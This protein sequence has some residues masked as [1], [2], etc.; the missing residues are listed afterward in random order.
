MRA[1]KEHATLKAEV[2]ERETLKA[3]YIEDLKAAEA[4]LKDKDWIKSRIGQYEARVFYF[5]VIE[6]LRK[7][8]VAG[9]SAFFPPGSFEKLVFGVLVTCFF[10]A[11]TARLSPYQHK[12]DDVL[13]VIY[14]SALLLTLT[15]AVLLKGAATDGRSAEEFA[16]FELQVGRALLT[17]CIAPIVCGGLLAVLDLV[18]TRRHARRMASRV[19]EAHNQGYFD[20]GFVGLGFGMDASAWGEGG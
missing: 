11:V 8:S 14:Q 19:S 18:A 15:L 2:K 16:Q 9:L 5:D 3:E 10:L 17:F 4:L 7:L 20:E 13:A 1:L 12:T 6:C